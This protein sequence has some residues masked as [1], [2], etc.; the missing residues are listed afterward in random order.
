MRHAT[1]E[2]LFQLIA[3]AN[4]RAVEEEMHLPFF[5]LPRR[6]LGDRRAGGLGHGRQPPQLALPLEHAQ[7]AVHLQQHPVY[8]HHIMGAGLF[9]QI[10]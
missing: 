8:T 9:T 2:Q 7:R 6:P 3:D 1:P 10:V 4:T 5:D